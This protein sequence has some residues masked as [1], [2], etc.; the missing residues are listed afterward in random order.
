MTADSDRRLA[1]L[2]GI[3]GA[4][5]IALEAAFDLVR[6]VVYLAIGHA[7]FGLDAFSQALILLVF[8]LLVGVFAVVGGQ[9]REARATVAGAVLLVL[10]VVGWLALGVGSGLVALLGL[11]L[12]LV[13]GVVFLVAGR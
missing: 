4:V 11:L 1:G 10:V 6:G 9:R 8:G 7:A 12:V 5:L 3:L 2:L 13:A